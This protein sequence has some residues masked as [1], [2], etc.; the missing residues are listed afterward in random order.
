MGNHPVSAAGLPDRRFFSS[1]VMAQS[2]QAN[3][4]SLDNL[5]PIYGLINRQP[6]ITETFAEAFDPLIV[7]V[8]EA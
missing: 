8:G 2:S 1:C 3:S 4:P 5:L 7:T 6:K